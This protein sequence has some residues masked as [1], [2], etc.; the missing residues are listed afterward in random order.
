CLSLPRAAPSPPSPY[1]PL[2]RSLEGVAAVIF[3]EFHDRSLHADLGLALCREAQ[4][5]LGLPLRLLVMSATIDGAAVAARLG[6]APVIEARGRSFPVQVHCLG[7]GLPPLPEQ[8]TLSPRDIDRLASQVRQVLQDTTGD[9]LAFLPGASEIHRLRPQ[10]EAG[11]VRG[12]VIHAL[13]G[14]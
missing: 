2:F 7:R 5:S 13:H 4:D 6:D 10:L 11:G 3:D 9:V 12:L 14:E 8:R 1:P